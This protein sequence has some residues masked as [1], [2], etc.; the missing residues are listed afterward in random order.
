MV[1]LIRLS[2]T[3]WR[4]GPSGRGARLVLDAV[5]YV[6]AAAY[7]SSLFSLRQPG[8]VGMDFGMHAREKAS[9]S[10]AGGTCSRLALSV[11]EFGRPTRWILSKGAIP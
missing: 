11:L 1:Y 6:V 9:P 2:T 4:L 3:V 5:F 7:L 10:L 8:A